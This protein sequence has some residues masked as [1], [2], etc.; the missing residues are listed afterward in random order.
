MRHRNL[1]PPCSASCRCPGEWGLTC[2][3]PVLSCPFLVFRWPTAWPQR[4]TRPRC[5]WNTK[6]IFYMQ[7]TLIFS[8]ALRPFPTS[9]PLIHH[10]GVF[11]QALLHCA[12]C[13]VRLHMRN[14]SFYLSLMAHNIFPLREEKTPGRLHWSWSTMFR[15]IWL[16]LP[17][18]L[19]S[20]LSLLALITLCLDAQSS[21]QSLKK[22]H[23]DVENL[24]FTLI[25][26]LFVF[27]SPKLSCIHICG[28]TASVPSEFIRSSVDC[29]SRFYIEW[30]LH[31]ICSASTF[32]RLRLH[33]QQPYTRPTI[34]R[35]HRKPSRDKWNQV[36][37][38]LERLCHV[39]CCSWGQVFLLL[40]CQSCYCSQCDVWNHPN[41]D[42]VCKWLSGHSEF[43][44]TWDPTVS[45]FSKLEII[46]YYEVCISVI[47]F[48][49]Q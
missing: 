37:C 7:H 13:N 43:V 11:I 31:L 29:K 15:N 23:Y 1:T 12:I 33:R 36:W 24:I 44:F 8:Q 39:S 49:W 9:T 35:K 10:S 3:R 40:H 34:W 19:L 18:K 20:L 27:F 28:K 42:L 4:C 26:Q 46:H 47:M 17:W 14:W 45:C 5:S 22:S 2:C 6:F 48:D 41:T 30:P 25:D 21:L 32:E 16:K 38:L